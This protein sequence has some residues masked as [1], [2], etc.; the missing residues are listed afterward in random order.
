MPCCG[1]TTQHLVP[2]SMVMR[3]PKQ[4][5]CTS[6][7]KRIL[8]ISSYSQGTARGWMGHVSH[9]LHILAQVQDHNEEWLLCSLRAAAQSLLMY[10]VRSVSWS[11]AQVVAGAGL[12]DGAAVDAWSLGCVLAE[13]AL[14][15][16]L[17]PCSSPGQLLAQVPAPHC[18]STLLCRKLAHQCARARQERGRLTCIPMLISLHPCRGLV[19]CAGTLLS[20]HLHA[21][22]LTISSESVGG[23]QGRQHR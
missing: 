21:C 14:Q 19:W 7:H 8:R 16:P 1:C 6:D 23:L 4:L 10:P 18:C 15:R 9:C 3:C 2:A 22:S 11:D 20:W 17:F 12:T 5:C 13:L